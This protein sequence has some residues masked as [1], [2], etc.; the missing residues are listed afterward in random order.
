MIDGTRAPNQAAINAAVALCLSRGARPTL[1]RRMVLEILAHASKPMSAYAV[2]DVIRAGRPSAAP[3]MVY[4]ALAFWR[5]EGVI[6]RL[7]S[8]SAYQLSLCERDEGSTYL[9]CTGCGTVEQ[10]TLPITPGQLAQHPLAE[11]FRPTSDHIEITGT[12]Q[13]CQTS[14][15]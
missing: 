8:I 7:D 5:R 14:G 15:D 1:A 12:C 2:L 3:V 4:R 13:R 9:I 6:V 10:V 11:G